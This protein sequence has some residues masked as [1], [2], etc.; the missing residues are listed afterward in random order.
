MAQLEVKVDILL[1]EV[2]EMKT[3][4][5]VLTKKMS[6][7]DG[8]RKLAMWVFTMFVAVGAAAGWFLNDVVGKG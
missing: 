3:N 4:Q 2:R 5:T 6:E 1:S 7:M 8:A